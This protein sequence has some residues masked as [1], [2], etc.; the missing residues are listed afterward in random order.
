M[1]TAALTAPLPELDAW[2]LRDLESRNGTVVGDQVVHGDYTLSPGDLIRVGRS[3]LEFVHEL[4]KAF[5]EGGGPAS[6]IASDEATLGTADD[7]SVLAPQEPT[8]ITHRR[9]QT[10]FLAPRSED[11]SSEVG[12]S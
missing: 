4:S 7:S 6:R 3:Q 11:D 9:G 5:T 8:T 1:P 12:I 2:I 10:R